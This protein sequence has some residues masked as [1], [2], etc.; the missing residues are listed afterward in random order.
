MKPN[1]VHLFG[2]QM[3]LVDDQGHGCDCD[4]L[5]DFDTA[6]QKLDCWRE[7]HIFDYDEAII[8]LTEHFKKEPVDEE[9]TGKLAL[10]AQHLLKISTLSCTGRP[11]LDFHMVHTLEL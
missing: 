4:T 2:T 5:C 8:L 10:I 11:D 1:S 7:K 9:I 6:K 3:F